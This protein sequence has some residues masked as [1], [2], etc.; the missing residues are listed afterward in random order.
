MLYGDIVLRH[1]AGEE[2]K[3]IVLIDFRFFIFVIQ[4]GSNAM[5]LNSG[6]GNLQALFSPQGHLEQAKPTCPTPDAIDDTRWGAGKGGTELNGA[7]HSQLAVPAK[8]LLLLV[9]V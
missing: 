3:Y 8:L 2:I 6:L 7:L 4:R 9:V 5:P 1:Q